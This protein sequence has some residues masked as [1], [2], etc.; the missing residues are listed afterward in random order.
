MVKILLALVRNNGCP[1]LL[2]NAL[3]PAPKNF[4]GVSLKISRVWQLK[5]PCLAQWVLSVFVLVPKST[6]LVIVLYLGTMGHS[7]FEYHLNYP[8]D[9]G[10]GKFRALQ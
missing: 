2:K 1:K 7:L 6:S 10:E 5:S 9:S 8:T 3:P 4:S